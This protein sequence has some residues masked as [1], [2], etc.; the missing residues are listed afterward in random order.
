MNMYVCVCAYVRE[1]VC[2]CVF[3]NKH[4]YSLFLAL[5]LSLSLSLSVSMYV[6]IYLVSSGAEKRLKSIQK[7]PMQKSA[8]EAR[9]SLRQSHCQKRPSIEAKET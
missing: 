5:S 2:V 4:T 9:A 3:A 6:Y 1:C 7:L 8:R